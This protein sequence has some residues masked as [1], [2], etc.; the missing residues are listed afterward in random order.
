MPAKLER[1]V[2]EVEKKSPEVDPWAVCK[3]SVKAEECDDMLVF[4]EE[5]KMGMKEEMEHAHTVDHDKEMIKKIVLDHLKEDPKY[6]SKM[7]QTFHSEEYDPGKG[8]RILAPIKKAEE[9]RFE[10]APKKDMPGVGV[11][12]ESYPEKMKVSMKSK[13][14]AALLA[15]AEEE[16]G[17][18]KVDEM[19]N[20]TIVEDFAN[21]QKEAE[22][23]KPPQFTAEPA[24]AEEGILDGVKKLLD[25]APK[26]P[27]TEKPVPL[28]KSFVRKLHNRA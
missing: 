8:G 9:E 21:K 18:D 2:E 12:K 4:P 26:A 28:T 10:T 11:K 17:K 6:Y 25:P 7:K 15:K 16:L 22:K 23:A 27:K 3:T 13:L 14:S 1:C 19:K 24:K 20:K 5:F